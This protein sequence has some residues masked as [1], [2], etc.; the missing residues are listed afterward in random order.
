M[1]NLFLD[2]VRYPK[3]TFDYTK[4]P[5]YLN[6]EWE[7]VRSYAQFVK[8]VTENGLPYMVSFD[9]DLAE[10]HYHHSMY[11]GNKVYMKYLETVSE[12][13]GMD[14][15]KWLVDYCI[16]NKLEFPLWYLHTMNPVGR[17]NMH[18]YITSYLK[19]V[20]M[21]EDNSCSCSDECA[22]KN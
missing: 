1:Y 13:T 7:I 11:V 3:H 18:S 8:F 20:T 4:N 21:P 17:E 2:D 6:E 16:D 9:H 12:K 15:V 14:C 10:A 22:C 19:T 5:I